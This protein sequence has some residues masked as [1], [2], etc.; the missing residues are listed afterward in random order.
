MRAHACGARPASR[1]AFTSS[2]DGVRGRPLTANVSSSY[3][4]SGTSCA[5]TRSGD[6]ANVTCTSRLDSSSATASAGS[7]CPAVP[8]AAIRHLSCRSPIPRDVKE[9]ADRD[10]LHHEARPAVRDERQRDPGQRR[11]PEDGRKV[12]RRLAAD[13]TGQA[14]G[15]PLAEG[16]PTLERGLQAGPCEE[17]IGEDERRGADEAE[18][19]ADDREDHVGV[20]LRQVVDL[21]DALPEP[22]AEEMSRAQADLRLD[23]LE[24]G[25]LRVLPR[26][27]KA[28]DAL[29]HVR[30]AEDDEQPHS[31]QQDDS[32]AERPQPRTGREEN[33]AGGQ[34][35]R[36]RGAEV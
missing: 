20:R 17:H 31:A 12:D 14:G 1:A 30:P 26:V 35:E 2:T 11:E 29:P 7:T 10:E 3:P 27:E 16:I 25:A 18:L 23:D 9:D 15:Q 32:A 13:E 4:A 34:R 24:S 21:L 5:S 19:L 33:H 22:L 6:P 36:D 28:E 8:P